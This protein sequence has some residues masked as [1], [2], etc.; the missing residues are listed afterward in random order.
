[1]E[2]ALFYEIPVARPWSRTAEL[3]AYQ[4]T[5]EQ[6]VAA[7]QL[8]WHSFWSVEHHFL[9]EYSHCSNPEVLYGAVAARTERLRIGYGVRLAPR[10]Y[11]HPV[12]SAESA[13]V[14]DLLSNGRVE[15]GTG[16]SSTRA[17]ME[18]FGIHPDETRPMWRE[19]IEHIVGCWTHDEYE[20]EGKYW[21][22]PRRRVLPKP[23]QDPHPPLWGA[24]GSD[25]GSRLMGELGIGF[26]SFS[27]GVPPEELA[28][29]V[30][31][32]REGLADCTQPVG[33]TVNPRAACF[34]M[35]NCAAT[36]E[37]S[38]EAARES[39]EW[40]PRAAARLLATVP[41]WLDEMDAGGQY[42]TYDYLTAAVKA[43]T[44]YER[45]TFDRLIETR[46]AIAGNPDD[47]VEL[48]RAYE[49][50]GTDLLLCLLN[51]YKVRHEDVM[52]TIEL[53]GRHVIPEFQ[54]SA[55][56]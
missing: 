45:L 42:G 1:V 50:T 5:L 32:Y 44:V 24:T 26:L 10:P 11:N 52:A 56:T 31:L 19:A 54:R 27:V 14:L 28:R 25:G 30:A 53:M 47:V 29:R 8:G 12:R 48:V 2:F 55:S 43:E 37:R 39:F 22:M 35:V 51:P 23:I 21:S 46:A 18:G 7:D 33:V 4:N 49:A 13:A 38:Y 41:K 9:E 34:T 15:F 3:E 6:V 40:Y 36:R 17:E 16:R 20:F